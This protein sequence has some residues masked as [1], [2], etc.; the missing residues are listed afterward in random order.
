MTNPAP[1]QDQLKALVAE[2]ALA[3]VPSGQ[4][5]GVDGGRSTLRTKG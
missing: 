1:T 4:V 2:A 5:I 3:H